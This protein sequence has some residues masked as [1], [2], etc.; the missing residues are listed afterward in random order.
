M[1]LEKF[2]AAYR[3]G[4]KTILFPHT[5]AKDV[6]E[7]PEQVKKEIKLIPV[8]HM[9]EV[10]PLALE[11]WKDYADKHA[12]DFTKA[13]A[14]VGKLVK[15]ESG[16]KKIDLFVVFESLCPFFETGRNNSFENGQYPSTSLYSLGVAGKWIAGRV[17]Q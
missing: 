12:K 4:V 10:L 17:V 8:K 7:L 5:N 16:K 1:P 3:E 6:A 11:G 2:L 9:D 14:A 15:K 13:L